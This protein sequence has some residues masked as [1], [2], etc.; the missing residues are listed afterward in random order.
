M[1]FPPGY[2]RSKPKTPRAG[3]LGTGGLAAFYRTS[4]SLDVARRRGP[5]VRLDPWRPARPRLLGAGG[6][7]W[8]TAYPAPQRIRAMNRVRHSGGRESANPES[9]DAGS[10]PLWI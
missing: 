4:T 1:V 8:T 7:K 10:V 2:S 3:R 6:W 5:W 9:R